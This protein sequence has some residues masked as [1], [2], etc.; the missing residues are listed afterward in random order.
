MFAYLEPTAPIAADALLVDDP[1]LAMDLAVRVCESPRMSNLAHG[2]WGYHGV[3]GAGAELTVQSLGIGGPSA[4][5]VVSELAELGLKRAVR[6]GSCVAID[7]SIRM[8]TVIVPTEIRARDG[9]GTSISSSGVVSPDRGLADSVRGFAAAGVQSVCSVDI[10]DPANGVDG[11]G[12]Y[13]LSSAATLASAS[14][15]G[16]ACCVALIVAATANGDAMERET[17]SERLV[18]LGESVTPAVAAEA[19]SA[20]P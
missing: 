19:Q 15:A 16:V 3:T 10:P 20:E 2:L 14:R 12:A 18:A 9:V 8:G 11:S 7:P 17:L 1:K 5:L 6:L 4:A 13:D